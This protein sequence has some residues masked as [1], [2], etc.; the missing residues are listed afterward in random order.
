MPVVIRESQIDE[1]KQ[2]LD[3]YCKA[4]EG[5]TPGNVDDPEELA[6]LMQH[7]VN[8]VKVQ[9]ENMGIQI[10]QSLGGGG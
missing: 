8:K 5:I 3:A 6:L 2:K 4:K 1:L 9:L 7:R 10:E